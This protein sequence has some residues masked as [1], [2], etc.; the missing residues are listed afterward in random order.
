LSANTVDYSLKGKHTAY[1]MRRK[2]KALPEEVGKMAKA[3]VDYKIDG[4]RPTVIHYPLSLKSPTERRRFRLYDAERV[5][6][7]KWTRGPLGEC[8]SEVH[9]YSILKSYY[10]Y[11]L[12]ER[13]ELIDVQS[14][15]N[16]SVY[17][18]FDQAFLQDYVDF[19]INRGVGF[20]NASRLITFLLRGIAEGGFIRHCVPAPGGST[21]AQWFGELDDLGVL[22]SVLKSELIDA[23]RHYK[24]DPKRNIRFILAMESKEAHAYINRLS[25]EAFRVARRSRVRRYGHAMRHAHIGLLIKLM[26]IAPLRAV[27]WLEMNYFADDGVNDLNHASLSYIKE[28]DRYRLFVPAESL[29]NRERQN[30]KAIDIALPSIMNAGIQEYIRYRDRYIS[31]V[32]KLDPDEI[33]ELTVGDCRGGR[34]Y[35]LGRTSLSS[36]FSCITFGLLQRIDK[37]RRQQGINIHAMR[38]L[39][40]TLYLRENPGDYPALATLLHDTL[41]V[42]VKE[43]AEVEA[44][45]NHARIEAWVTKHA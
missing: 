28:T 44:D 16:S 37:D 35:H 11:L 6:R 1:T 10:S 9:F 36:R 41:D 23:D 34:T 38:H 40:A 33:R 24:P 29:K 21:T 5:R 43:Y 13:D 19:I 7:R 39:M 2:L 14:S 12:Y 42:V 3:Y 30:I 22:L 25:E 20:Q 32:L 45:H 8:L 27:N 26:K 4:V 31:K 17:L 18:L 15:K